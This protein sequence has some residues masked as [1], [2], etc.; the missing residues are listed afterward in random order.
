MPLLSTAAKQTFA[1]KAGKD[2]SKFVGAIETIIFFDPDLFSSALQAQGKLG[3]VATTAA[4][5]L[6]GSGNSWV[7]NKQAYYKM[8]IN[9]QNL[10][11]NRAKIQSEVLTKDDHELQYHNEGMITYSYSGS[12]GYMQ[13]M[14]LDLGIDDIR[15]SPAWIKLKGLESYYTETIK[16]IKMI[17]AGD[18]HTGYFSNFN[19]RDD[20][21][22]P[23]MMN[24]SFVFKVY[25]GRSRGLSNW[26]SIPAVQASIDLTQLLGQFGVPKISIL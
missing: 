23:F 2:F 14:L 15:F 5:I 25:P 7:H 20:A 9:P 11:I 10:D 24:Y 6:K 4:T 12:T 18:I 26:A 21:N 13:S 1:D 3:K 17:Y 8:R 22:N 16:N 19:V